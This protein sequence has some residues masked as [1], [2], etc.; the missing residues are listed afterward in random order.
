MSTGQL[1]ASAIFAAT[2]DATTVWVSSAAGSDSNAG[3]SP[4]AALR[5]LSVGINQVGHLKASELYVAGTHYLNETLFI[6]PYTSGGG[7]TLL[8]DKWPDQ[9][10]PTL[11]GAQILPSSAWLLSGG[12]YTAQVPNAQMAESLINEASIFVG[13]SRARRAMVRTPTLRWNGTLTGADASK[14]FI[15]AA[16]DVSQTPSSLP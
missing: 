3:T 12:V 11:S 10:A 4:S 6:D 16:E 1:L 7:P 9:P 14:G 15:F 8:V 2:A 5:T 13:A